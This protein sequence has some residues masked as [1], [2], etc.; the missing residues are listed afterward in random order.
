MENLTAEDKGED[1]ARLSK[2]L[3]SLNSSKYKGH[4]I[5]MCLTCSRGSRKTN[6]VGMEG[7]RGE[8]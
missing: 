1:H 8:R 3:P 4:E 2:S 7:A 6:T 5:G